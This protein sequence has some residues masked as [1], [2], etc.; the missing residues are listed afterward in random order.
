MMQKKIG[1]DLDAEKIRLDVERLISVSSIC[2]CQ[3]KNKSKL[4]TSLKLILQLSMLTLPDQ[5]S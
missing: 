4:K 3:T 2:F 1:L 5:S